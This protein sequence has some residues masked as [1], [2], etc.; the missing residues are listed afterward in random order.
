MKKKILSVL[1]CLCMVCMLLPTAAFAEE[2]QPEESLPGEQL[3]QVQP[4]PDEPVAPQADGVDVSK[5]TNHTSWT[6]IKMVSGGKVLKDNNEWTANAAGYYVLDSGNYYLALKSAWV[7][8][9]RSQG[10]PLLPSA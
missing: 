10:V 4:V 3:E 9:F 5:H 2:A 8:P 7:T 6:E 1:L